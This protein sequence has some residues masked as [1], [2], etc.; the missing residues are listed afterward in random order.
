MVFK[1]GG[2]KGLAYIGVVKFLESADFLVHVHRI[3]GA[4]AGSIIATLLAVG[5]S[6]SEILKLLHDT[7]TSNFVDFSLSLRG[8][9]KGEAFRQWLDTVIEKKTKIKNCTFGELRKLIKND[10]SWKHLHVFISKVGNNKEIVHVS[11]EDQKWRNLIISDAVRASISLPV[12]FPPHI[13]HIKDEDGKRIKCKKYGAFM[14]GGFLANYPVHSFDRKTYMIPKPAS[15]NERKK[16]IFNKKTL[17]FFL[18][19]PEE[20]IN[21]KDNYRFFM[22][23]GYA[24]YKDMRQEAEDVIRKASP[25]EHLR[26]V[27]I[28]N[29]DVRTENFFPNQQLVDSLIE[30]GENSSIM[31]LREQERH[32]ENLKLISKGKKPKD[33]GTYRKVWSYN[34]FRHQNSNLTIE[35]D[36]NRITIYQFSQFPIFSRFGASKKYTFEAFIQIDKRFSIFSHLQ[37]N[38]ENEAQEILETNRLFFENCFLWDQFIKLVIEANHSGIIAFFDSNGFSFN[39]KSGHPLWYAHRRHCWQSFESLL[40]I[41]KID[42]RF[43]NPDTLSTQLHVLVRS[44]HI[45]SLAAYCRALPKRFPEE[46]LGLPYIQQALDIAISYQEPEAAGILIEHGADFEEKIEGWAQAIREK[47][48]PFFS[49]SIVQEGE[50]AGEKSWLKR[51]PSF[52]FALKF[53]TW[54]FK[55]DISSEIKINLL[56]HCFRFDDRDVCSNRIPFNRLEK[57]IQKQIVPYS[58][59]E[60]VTKDGRGPLLIVLKSWH[61]PYSSQQQLSLVKL[62]LSGDTPDD[63]NQ[64]NDRGVT[65]LIIAAKSNYD[66]LSELLTDPSIEV[67]QQDSLGNTALHYAISRKGK[68]RSAALIKHSGIDPNIRNN[69]GQTPLHLT[70]S[71]SFIKLLVDGGASDRVRDNSGKTPSELR[72]FNSFF[73]KVKRAV[74][75]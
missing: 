22:W 2:A 73:S 46:D 75:F 8:L 49:Y 55:R 13:L 6:S 38:E 71:S 60:M 68:R 50:H 66:I 62:L 52:R 25:H 14:D 15:H 26:M 18:H 31:F 72:E 47:E 32:A 7:P 51:T 61:C 20:F 59:K 10:A 4:S 74:N 64:A 41:P 27:K 12:V 23:D 3:A 16:P 44:G 21:K 70:S 67:N 19:N 17:G 39:L 34:Y 58:K 35:I 36:G 63:V 29:L 45:P 42:I 24:N 28:S 5:Y 53:F 48:Q 69:L 9:C 43:R 11:S 30:C 33:S 37:R 54:D 65:P 40:K 1:G 57:F 56:N